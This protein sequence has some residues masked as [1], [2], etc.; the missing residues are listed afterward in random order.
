MPGEGPPH[1]LVAAFAASQAYWDRRTNWEEEP[2]SGT[3]YGACE[4]CE[5]IHEVGIGSTWVSVNEDRGLIEKTTKEAGKL[6]WI[7]TT[8]FGEGLWFEARD[9]KLSGATAEDLAAIEDLQMLGTTISCINPGCEAESSVDHR[10]LEE[11]MAPFISSASP[12]VS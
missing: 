5:A 12:I 4:H 1:P 10:K 11:L 7:D 9:S 3:S 2:F 6:P 8:K